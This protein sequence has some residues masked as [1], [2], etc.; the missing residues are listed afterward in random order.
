MRSRNLRAALLALPLTLFVA[1]CLVQK[2]DGVAVSASAGAGAGDLPWLEPDERRRVEV[3]EETYGS[4]VYIRNMTL[5]RDFFSFDI[6]EEQQGSGSGFVWDKNGHI[7]TNYHVVAGAHSVIVVL[8]DQTGA[9]A[10]VVGVAPDKDLAVLK[11]DVPPAKLL[12]I[13]VGDSDTLRVGMNTLAI[14]NP[15][16]LDHSLT[17]GIISALGREIRSLTGRT[18]TDVIQTDAAINPG[19]SGGPLL[20]SRGCLIGVNTAIVSP[21]GTSAGVGFAVPVGTVRRVASQILRYGRVIRPGLGAAYYRD[22]IS[23][24]AGVG[25]GVLIRQVYRGS[26]AARAGLRGTKVFVNGDVQVGDI[27]IKI[28]THDI[29]DTEDLLNTLDRYKVGDIVDLSYVRE[30]KMDTVKV[31]LQAVD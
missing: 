4:V 9:R 20:D 10:R 1:A 30:G 14:G 24:R 31:T 22:A 17:R 6:S 8:S 12:P 21:S 29:L 11:I 13:R 16:G 25:R 26:A 2:G 18:I 5:R 7:V 28:D 23:R 3:F 15:F 19:N 27:I